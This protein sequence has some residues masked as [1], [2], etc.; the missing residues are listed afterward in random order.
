M[1]DLFILW[2]VYDHP[3][4]YPEYFVARKWIA[5]GK[6]A[7]PI[8]TDVIFF[9]T[10]LERLRDMLPAGLYPLIRAPEDDKCIIE[11]WI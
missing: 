6:S 9:H 10:D 1:D 3:A 7:E 11:T 8:A 4:D 2:T 5:D